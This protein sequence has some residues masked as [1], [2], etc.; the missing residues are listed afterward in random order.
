MIVINENIEYSTSDDILNISLNEIFSYGYFMLTSIK[1][2]FKLILILEIGSIRF[3]NQF[4]RGKRE[5]L[6]NVFKKVELCISC[7]FPISIELV[8]LQN[9]IK[10]DRNIITSEGSFNLEIGRSLNIIGNNFMN[11]LRSEKLRKMVNSL[12]RGQ[13]VLLLS[14]EI[15]EF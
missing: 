7:N 3:S 11:P 10:F 2:R 12:W 5:T 6:N 9:S 13:D 8:N 4:W 1:S 14:I 15:I